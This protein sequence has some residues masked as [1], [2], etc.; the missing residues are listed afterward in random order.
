[1]QN[2]LL[3]RTAKLILQERNG[4]LIQRQLFTVSGS[5]RLYSA[6]PVRQWVFI[7]GKSTS[8]PQ[9]LYIQK[10]FYVLPGLLHRPSATNFSVCNSTGYL[11]YLEHTVSRTWQIQWA[12]Y[13]AC[14][15]WREEQYGLD[16]LKYS[17]LNVSLN[18]TLRTWG[19][20]HSCCSSLLTAELSWQL[21]P[22]FD[23]HMQKKLVQSLVSLLQCLVCLRNDTNCQYFSPVR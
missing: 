10:S 4:N 18:S 1:M 19:K 22:S 2:F 14:Y 16:K 15:L 7:A 23:G 13:S 5:F 21:R 3:A 6:K 11:V 17:Y 8:H 12:G 20:N 9:N